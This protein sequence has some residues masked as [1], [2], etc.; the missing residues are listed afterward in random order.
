MLDKSRRILIVNCLP[1]L[2]HLLP[3]LENFLTFRITITTGQL[4][5]VLFGT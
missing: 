5:L 3:W 4:C 1:H 2:I